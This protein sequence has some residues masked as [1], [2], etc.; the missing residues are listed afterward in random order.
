[1]RASSTASSS[2][3]SAT[4]SASRCNSR[5]R[6]PGATARQA[7]QAALDRATAASTSAA[8]ARSIVARTSSVAGSR[9]ESVDATRYAGV[10]VGGPGDVGGSSGSSSTM[11]TPSSNEIVRTGPVKWFFALSSHHRPTAMKTPP[12]MSGA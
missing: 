1:L 4:V 10:A 6:S 8:V 11:P 5:A 2:W 7:G 12:T 3:C 9:T